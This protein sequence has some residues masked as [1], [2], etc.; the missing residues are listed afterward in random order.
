MTRRRRVRVV[1]VDH[2]TS[3]V[4]EVGRNLRQEDRDELWELSRITGVAA[5]KRSVELSTE[6]YVAY[7][8]QIPI[9]IFGASI[10]AI[11]EYGVPWFL[12]TRGVDRCARD[13]LEMGHKFVAHLFTRCEEL[14][15]MASVKNERT[16]AF[17]SRLGFDIGEPFRTLTGAC[18]VRFTMKRGDHV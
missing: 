13:Y 15:N 18:A 11:G 16:L 14:E 4:I 9:A 7:D 5:A 1:P 3:D 6:A 12:G 2:V 10:P 8:G 17:L